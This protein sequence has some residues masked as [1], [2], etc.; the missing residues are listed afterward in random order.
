MNRQLDEGDPA[1][2]SIALPG[3]V[4]PSP[5][6]GR[7]MNCASCHLSDELAEQDRAA[8]R[9]F[10]GFSR[11]SLLPDRGDGRQVTARNAAALVDALIPGA[12]ALF[13]HQDGEYVS[14]EELVRANLTGRNFGWLPTE[15]AQAVEHIAKLVRLD[16]GRDVMASESAGLSYRVLFAATAP[17]IPEGLRLPE[18]LRADVMGA[19]DEDALAAV[20]RVV[21]AYLAA[22]SLA[23]IGSPYD[24]FLRKNNLPVSPS[25]GESV[26]DYG[27]RLYTSLATLS[28]PAFVTEADGQFRR[29]DQQFV[30]GPLELAGL[31][32]FLGKP[33]ETPGGPPGL[34]ACSTCHPPPHFTDFS[35]HN[36]GVTELEYD[37]IHGRGSF[38]ALAVPSL[39]QRRKDEAAFLPPSPRI[40]TGTSIFRAVADKDRPGHTDLGVWNVLANEDAAA[41]QPALMA[42]LCPLVKDAQG[43]CDLNQLLGRTVASFKTRGL[44]NLGHSGP[45]FHNGQA[46]TLEE[47]VNHYISA[48]LAVKTGALWR[49]DEAL[50]WLSLGPAN[51]PPIAAFLRSLNED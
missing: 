33:G 28:A 35:F 48:S 15:R 21:A 44:R 49:A 2:S 45:Y 39:E 16:D 50:E 43:A 37:G 36:T 24:R 6:R 18:G 20:A 40:P 32:T 3:A 7:S 42:A 9:A 14:A 23:H 47:A 25:A 31:I 51:V 34:W 22:Q 30:F 41:A 17:E 38:A 29:H 46:P 26:A 4:V 19:S 27:R 10:A 12:P 8:A 11:H 1:V 13:L 5:Y